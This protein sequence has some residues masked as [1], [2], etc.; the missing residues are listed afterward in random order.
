[1]RINYKEA[2]E[3]L[4]ELESEAMKRWGIFRMNKLRR[5]YVDARRTFNRITRGTSCMCEIEASK[6]EEHW[7]SN[8]SYKP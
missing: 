6:D 5:D 2:E 4:N 7:A 1:M 8:W 3:Q